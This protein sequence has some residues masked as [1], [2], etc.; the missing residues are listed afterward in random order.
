MNLN[1]YELHMANRQYILQLPSFV[2]G[3][4]QCSNT[5]VVYEIISRHQSI[6]FFPITKHK[7]HRAGRP[8]NHS[9]IPSRNKILFCFP[10][11]PD[12]HWGTPRAVGKNGKSVKLTRLHP[13]QWLRMSGCYTSTTHAFMVRTGT[14]LPFIQVLKPSMWL[15]FRLRQA[16]RLSHRI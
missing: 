5:T 9:S 7:L 6:N 15:S 2:L 8:R 1:Q 16:S 11:C 10:I 4:G 12:W 3:S 13:V 14:A